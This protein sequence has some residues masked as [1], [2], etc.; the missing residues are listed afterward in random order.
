DVPIAHTLRFKTIGAGANGPSQ[1]TIDDKKFDGEDGVSVVLNQTEAW[2]IVNETYAPSISHPF[3]I[4]INPFQ[5]TE[6]FDPNQ[7]IRTSTGTLIPKYV[8]VSGQPLQQGQCYVNPLEPSTW[9]PCDSKPSL[10]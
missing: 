3:H 2:K 5:I 9:H 6:V 4:H 8:Y 10:H 1:Q 7:Q